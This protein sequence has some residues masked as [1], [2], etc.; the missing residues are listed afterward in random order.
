MSSRA[1]STTTNNC[2]SPV[3]LWG[4]PLHVPDDDAYVSRV[5]AA[6]LLGLSERGVDY[7]ITAGKL[8]VARPGDKSRRSLLREDVERLA[9]CRQAEAKERRA[10]DAARVR[11]V[12]KRADPPGEEWVSAEEAA[13]MLGVTATWVRRLASDDRLPHAVRGSVY[14]FRR[15]LL[16]QVVDA[17]EAK[18]RP[19]W[20]QR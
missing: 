1:G 20:H 5:M 19:A 2:V 17:R 4:M 18:E 10:R 13:A 16:R 9:R 7:L 3:R 8:P 12:V 14:R 15:D 11:R 6:E